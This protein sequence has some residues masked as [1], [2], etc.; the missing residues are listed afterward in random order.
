LPHGPRPRREAEPRWRSISVFMAT[1][2]PASGAAIHTPAWSTTAA[3][4]TQAPRRQ[5]SSF[6]GVGDSC[7]EGARQRAG[8]NEQRERP[9]AAWAR[10]R[11]G[12]DQSHDRSREAVP[13]QIEHQSSTFPLRFVLCRADQQVNQRVK[14][15]TKVPAEATFDHGGVRLDNS[16]PLRPQNRMVRA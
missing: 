6:N 1:S 8:S 12:A 15:L 16:S 5:R 2:S 9:L 11:R 14:K 3:T 7:G 13:P 4:L 10:S